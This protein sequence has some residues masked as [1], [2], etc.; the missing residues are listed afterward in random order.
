[1]ESTHA[2]VTSYTYYVR[3]CHD[4]GDAVYEETTTLA[5]LNA[6]QKRLDDGIHFIQSLEMC[7]S[8]LSLAVCRSARAARTHNGH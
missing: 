7:L 4:S 1:M 2:G 8:D 3:V 5:W 6:A